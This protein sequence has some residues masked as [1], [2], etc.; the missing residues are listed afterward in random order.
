MNAGS[1]SEVNIEDQ[2]TN[3]QSCNRGNNWADCSYIAGHSRVW[4]EDWR[5]VYIA[6]V[7][8]A[9]E[10][11]AAAKCNVALIT[12]AGQPKAK[13]AS[14]RLYAHGPPEAPFAIPFRRLGIEYTVRR[15]D[16]DYPEFG[17]HMIENKVISWLEMVY[18]PK[19][20]TPKQMDEFEELIDRWL[21][22]HLNR[23]RPDMS[24]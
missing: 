22:R 23:A 12:L 5:R 6:H 9:A 16:K 20:L 13:R 2:I 7:A 1:V 19:D 21:K 10:A 11:I 15:I 8:H 3:G 4:R 17:R 24:A 18:V 14:P